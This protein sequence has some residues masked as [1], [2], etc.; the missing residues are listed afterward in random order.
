MY[1]IEDEKSYKEVT[2]YKCDL[3]LII[4]LRV[5][6]TSCV[7]QTQVARLRGLIVTDACLENDRDR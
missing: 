2:I 6:H 7:G 4:D 5:T 3:M 1:W